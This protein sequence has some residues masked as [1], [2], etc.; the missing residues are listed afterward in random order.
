MAKIF[1]SGFDVVIPDVTATF[2]LEYAYHLFDNNVVLYDSVIET[3]FDVYF[4]FPGITAGQR[5][6]LLADL[7]GLT[8]G[9]IKSWNM[10]TFYVVE[11]T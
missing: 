2:V 3:P 1:K 4:D 7:N 8:F 6:R 9:D 5:G 10:N 11:V